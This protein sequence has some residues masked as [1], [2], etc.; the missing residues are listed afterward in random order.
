MLPTLCDQPSFA[1]GEVKVVLESVESKAA[2]LL[3]VREDEDESC[4]WRVRTRDRELRVL[5]K[6]CLSDDE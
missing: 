6:G 4:L 2:A 3:R 1:P 5:V